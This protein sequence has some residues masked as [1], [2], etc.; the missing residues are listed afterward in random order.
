MAILAGGLEQWK[1]SGY[2]VDNTKPQEESKVELE[3]EFSDP[4]NYLATYADIKAIENETDENT[5][6]DVRSPEEHEGKKA[7]A[8]KTA[9]AGKIPNSVN[10]PSG[11]L[12][13]EDGSFKPVEELQEIFNQSGIDKEKQIICHCNNGNQAT[14]VVVALQEAGYKKVKLYD[15]SWSEYGSN[16]S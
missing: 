12:L 6:V 14:V 13:Q 4:S 11:R 3:E 2:P 5:I 9:K 10:L 7:P 8:F 1:K 15:G 16:L